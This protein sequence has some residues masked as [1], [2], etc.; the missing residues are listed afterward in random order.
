[1]I[2]YKGKGKEGKVVPV[3]AIE[4]YRGSEV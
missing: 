2:K 1:M 4:A 3:H